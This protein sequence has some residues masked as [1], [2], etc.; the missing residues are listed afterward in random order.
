KKQDSS[1]VRV[2]VHAMTIEVT[3]QAYVYQGMCLMM[4][5]PFTETLEVGKLAAVGKYSVVDSV[6]KSKLGEMSI[7][8]SRTQGPDDYHYA[9]VVDAYLEMHEGRVQVVVKG[10]LPNQ[11]WTLAET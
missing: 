10:E 11:C 7:A 1:D 8:E 4:L 9:M 2:D 6:T 3:Q 5:V